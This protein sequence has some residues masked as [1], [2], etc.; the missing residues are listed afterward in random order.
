[1]FGGKSN[2]RKFQCFICG[3][4]H[5]SFEEFK[6][7][8]IE[9]HEEGTDYIPCPLERCKAPVRDM[10][11]HFK[12][13]HPSEAIPKKGMMKATVWRDISTK[14]QIKKRKARFRE[15][16]HQSTKMQKSF[17]YRSGYEKIVYECLDSWNEVVAYQAEP[18]KIPYIHEGECHEYTPDVF[19][20]FLN[21][22]K[23]VWEIKPANQTLLERN[24][25]KWFSAKKA[26]E[27]RG[28]GFEV[29]TEQSINKL[30][31]KAKTQH[32]AN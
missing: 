17:Y 7:H 20:A 32:L 25:N 5:D 11:A 15:G 6:S 9:N 27:A 24:Q 2:I 3:V 1:M 8:I 26:C 14:G 4:M 19:I 21:D 23:E 28:W 13:K 10:K 22:R 16:W 31:K 30:K 18:F 12:A 29:I